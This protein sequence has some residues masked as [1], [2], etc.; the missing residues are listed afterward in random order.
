MWRLLAR[1]PRFEATMSF[2]HHKMVNPSGVVRSLAA[3]VR[4]LVFRRGR[5]ADGGSGFGSDNWLAPVCRVVLKDQRPGQALYLRG[6]APLDTLL[7]ATVEGGGIF[8][9]PLRANT[10]QTIRLGEA[11]GA[12]CR[13]RLEFSTHALL[14]G[15][16][17]VAFLVEETN[18]FTEP[19]AA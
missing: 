13:L 2:W 12:G 11:P 15:R 6:A 16:R 3:A 19:E 18:L 7:T 14:P 1:L 10:S 9:Y 8:V 5:A 17:K 4:N